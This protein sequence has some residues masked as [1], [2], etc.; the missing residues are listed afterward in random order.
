MTDFAIYEGGLKS[1]YYDVISSI[2]DYF[3]QRIQTLQQKWKKCESHN[4][5]YVRKK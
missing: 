2:D 5:D 4:G 1:S 3:E